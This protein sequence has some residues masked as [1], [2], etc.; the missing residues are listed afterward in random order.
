MRWSPSRRQILGASLAALAAAPAT[1]A[2]ATAATPSPADG[3]SASR[4]L[5]RARVTYRALERYFDTA[6][7]SGLVR[8][9]YPVAVDDRPYSYEWPLSQVHV[10]ALDLA[11]VDP[12]YAPALATRA[13]A[14][15]L[16]WNPAGGTTG[17][18][19]YDSYP[20][21]PHGDGGDMFYD[22]NEWVGLAKSQLHLQTGDR[23]ALRRAEEIFALVES[24]WDTD[25]EH[26][27]PGGVFW[28][29]ADWNHWR[30]TV[31]NMPG[32]QLGLRLHQI[33][34]ASRYL[35]SSR[36]FYD[37]TNTHLRTPEYLYWDN[38]DL[39]GTVDRTVWSYNQGVPVGVGVLLYEAT[40]DRTY[41]NQA[42]RTAEAA[43]THF[44]TEDRLLSQ[45]VFFNSIFFKNLL[46]LESV[47]GGSVY[48]QAMA[49][50]A[51]HIWSEQR[52][53]ATGLMRFAENGTT[54]A[55]EQAAAVQ[56]FAVLSW[57]RG[58]WRTL[59]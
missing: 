10:A 37:W 47:T 23:A 46:L 53:S 52:D 22:D 45:P 29:Q 33:T 2:V 43:Y 5:S 18:A 26:P 16:Y 34:G 55:I 41:L 7:G 17:L 44:V 42:R 38:L 9:Q 28:T 3:R 11:F 49:D 21:A 58:A 20:V 4:S 24:G 39:A 15:E 50:Y 12:R 51:D 32:A 31:S 40:R 19:G 27:S 56:V 8:E 48:R 57:P 13:R 14:Q 6:D 36:R 35:E 59:Y 25:A 1:A 30:N 54:Q